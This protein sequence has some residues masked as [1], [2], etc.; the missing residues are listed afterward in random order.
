MAIANHFV[1]NIDLPS[2]TMN[3]ELEE[4]ISRKLIH[5][6]DVCNEKKKRFEPDT[7]IFLYVYIER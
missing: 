2:K 4:G 5:N 1:W 7:F 3:P 6:D